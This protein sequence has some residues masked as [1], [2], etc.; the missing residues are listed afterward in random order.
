MSASLVA[1]GAA[2]AG[3]R[4]L[5]ARRIAVLV[6]LA[7]L[8]TASLLLDI[9]TGPS[10]LGLSDVVRVLLNPASASGPVSVIVWDVRLPYAIMAVLVGAALALAGAEM[11]TV[12]NNPLASPFTLGVSS[13]ASLG[14]ALAIVLGVGLPWVPQEWLLSGNAFLFAFGSVL[15]LRTLSRLRGAGVEALVLFGIALVF[16]FNAAVALL[17]FVATEQALQQLVFWSMGSLARAS[18]SKI[19]IMALALAV[20][21]PFSARAAWQLTALRLGEERALSFGI[22]ADRLRDAALLRVSLLSGV[23]VAFVGTIGFIG[24]IGPHAARLLVGEDHR[25]FLPASALCGA[26]LLSLSSLASKML[27]PG[28][29]IPIGIVTAL[30][31][32]PV[33]VALVFTRGRRAG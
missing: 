26:L 11:Q 14:A 30:V 10:R 16:A 20:A 12:L 2:A 33:F 6:G 31:G 27:V 23:S 32:V 1:P 22:N 15:L 7:L 13:A 18:W 21:I 28:L 29:L 3:Y 17:Q 25:F 19:G 5:L 8:L 9:A 24:L 4:A